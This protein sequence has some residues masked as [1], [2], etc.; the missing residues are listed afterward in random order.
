MVED[1]EDETFT[2]YERTP[3][4]VSQDPNLKIIVDF[5]T[6]FDKRDFQK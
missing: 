4:E 5:E 1:E 6:Q 3:K 2:K